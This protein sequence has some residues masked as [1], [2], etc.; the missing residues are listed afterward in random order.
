[1]YSALHTKHQIKINSHPCGI[2]TIQAS[3]AWVVWMQF[4]SAKEIIGVK[5]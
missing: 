5:C 4:I 1:M 3:Q 2:Q